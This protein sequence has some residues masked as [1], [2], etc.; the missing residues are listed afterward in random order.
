MAGDESIAILLT[1]HYLDEADRL[2]DR[3]AIV[4]KGRIVIEGR[5]N[6]LKGELRGDAVERLDAGESSWIVRLG[7]VGYTAQS[8]VYAVV[9]YFFIQAAIAFKS[10]T[11]KGPSGALIELADTPWG[12]VLLWIIAIGLFAYGVFCIA[13]AKYRKAA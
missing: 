7:L 6:E 8:L 10:T 9:G 4:D 11:A 12:K 3:L 5:P 13:E 1:T 2:A